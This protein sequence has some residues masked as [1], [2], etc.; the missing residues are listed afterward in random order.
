MRM[1]S[2]S[3]RPSS[4]VVAAVSQV[5]RA[6]S[7]CAPMALLDGSPAFTQDIEP[8]SLSLD[9]PS[10]PLAKALTEFAT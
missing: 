8:S 6:L 4:A 3:R 1:A 9:I 5:L 2:K 7:L 10:Q